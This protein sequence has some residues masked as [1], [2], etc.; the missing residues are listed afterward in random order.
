MPPCSYENGRGCMGVTPSIPVAVH[1]V[2]E[3]QDDCMMVG[4]N[5]LSVGVQIVV[6]VSGGD[7]RHVCFCGVYLH[8]WHRA[9]TSYSRGEAYF[10]RLHPSAVVDD[11]PRL[12][13]SRHRECLHTCK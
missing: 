9:H 12:D 13:S 6:V 5:G 4:A 7:R 10:E 8:E 1:L 3:A 2:T 11:D